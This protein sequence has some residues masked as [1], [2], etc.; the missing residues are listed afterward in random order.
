MR[1]TLVNVIYEITGP[2]GDTKRVH[3]AGEGLDVGERGLAKALT[4]AYRNMLI[5]ALTIPTDDPKL[6]PDQV[7]MRREEPVTANP[8]TYRDEITDP[9][10]SLSRLRQIYGELAQHR[11]AGAMVVNEV[12]DEEVLG[13]LY[14]RVVAERRAAGADQ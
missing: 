10:T 6:D 9:R 5:V 1:E 7:E 11:I 13:K 8:N 14:Q 12:G 4:T 2:M 3:S